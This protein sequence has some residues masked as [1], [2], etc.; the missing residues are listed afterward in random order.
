MVFD[1][2]APSQAQALQRREQVLGPTDQLDDG[3]D[4][5]S[6]GR[7][8]VDICLLRRRPLLDEALAVVREG[9]SGPST[10]ALKVSPPP[11]SAKIADVE[12]E[13][14]RGEVFM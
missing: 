8:P 10:G 12:P 1:S 6:M 7:S 14:E 5:V 9:V 3:L 4:G 11:M 2:H 13:R